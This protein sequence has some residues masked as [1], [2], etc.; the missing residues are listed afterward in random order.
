MEPQQTLKMEAELLL[1]Q[2]GF[3][4]AKAK[5]PIIMLES[6]DSVQHTMTELQKETFLLMDIMVRNGTNHSPNLIHQ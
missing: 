1:V 5:F 2:W 6:L 3:T 4:V